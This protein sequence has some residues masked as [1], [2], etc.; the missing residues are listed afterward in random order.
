[1]R[2]KV[3]ASMATHPPRKGSVVLA[4]KSLLPQVDRLNIYL[5][6]Y[7]SVPR[8]LRHPKINAVLS[9]NGRGDLG[10]AGKFFWAD[11]VEGYHLTVDDDILYPS[12]YV[13]RQVQAVEK[14]RRRALVGVHARIWR[15][16]FKDYYRPKR[17]IGWTQP[18]KE[19]VFV[20]TLGTGTLCYHT[21]TLK[22]DPTLFRY[23]NMADI[24]LTVL[25]KKLGVPMVSLSRKSGWMT[26]VPGSQEVSIF[27]N[28]C[29]QGDTRA[30]HREIM[31]GYNWN[32][33]GIK[34]SAVIP[35]Q[36]EEDVEQARTTLVSLLRQHRRP[37][38][39]VVRTNSNLF[40]KIGPDLIDRAEAVRGDGP[41]ELAELLIPAGVFLPPLYIWEC[42]DRLADRDVVAVP[43]MLAEQKGPADLWGRVTFWRPDRGVVARRTTGDGGR[44]SRLFGSV[45]RGG[46]VKDSKS[47]GVSRGVTLIIPTYNRK[48]KVIRAIRSI[49]RR[50]VDEVLV[51]D[52]NKKP[53]RL[54]MDGVTF[55]PTGG[56]GDEGGSYSR[57]C[58]LF[59]ASFDKIVY[60]DD[61]DYLSGPGSVS[62]RSDALDEHELVW[63]DIQFD[64]YAAVP[65]KMRVVKSIRYRKG[66]LYTN[67]NNTIIGSQIAHRQD[68]DKFRWIPGGREADKRF[69]LAAK[70]AGADGARVP[71]VVAHYG[72]SVPF[73]GSRAR[74]PTPGVEVS[75]AAS[76]AHRKPLRR[77]PRRHRK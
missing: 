6:N 37:D 40:D 45:R 69:I 64:D 46:A 19:D 44:T 76:S 18:S 31:S 72:R 56:I 50:E 2:D 27:S 24:W 25:A 39:I 43:N 30:K 1:L 71:R 74:V 22:I 41:E 14:Y 66:S 12:D 7:S 77:D 28:T 36:N 67:H 73:W 4:A 62:S 9:K 5:N 65:S 35:V 42:L 47:T 38:H 20:H 13:S 33:R 57:N 63:G 58:G 16:G 11:Q 23:P 60:L 70:E 53:M 32:D 55:I 48:E 54:M 17:V 59:A 26:M 52:D 21:S 61:D 49:P 15:G 51:A 10:D 8:A 68:P 34:V 3:T 29:P 75:R